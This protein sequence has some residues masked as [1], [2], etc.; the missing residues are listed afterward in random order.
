MGSQEL[1]K[2]CPK[3]EHKNNIRHDFSSLDT[4]L[5]MSGCILVLHMFDMDTLPETVF[6]L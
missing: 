6:M 1:R 2:S 4:Y 3:L 5:S